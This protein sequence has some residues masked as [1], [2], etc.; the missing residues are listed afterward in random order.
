MTASL[1]AGHVNALQKRRATPRPNE[2]RHRPVAWR[3]RCGAYCRNWCNVR[4]VAHGAPASATGLWSPAKACTPQR[5]HRWHA[6]CNRPR[7]SGHF[8]IYP[9]TC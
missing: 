7:A 1:Y 9:M 4:D 3:M 6:P 2:P 8:R 5:P